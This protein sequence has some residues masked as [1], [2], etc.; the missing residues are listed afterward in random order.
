MKMQ[1]K[2][3]FLCL[4]STKYGH[5]VETDWTERV[6][7]KPIDRV[8][9]PAGPI[10]SGASRPLCS[11]PFSRG[12]GRPS[13]ERGSQDPQS[14]KGG[15]IISLGPVFTQKGGGGVR[16]ICLAFMFMPGFGETGLWLL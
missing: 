4:G 15:Q 14:N 9:N 12:G 11:T 1:K 5:H 8:G 3:S 2:D 6:W 7:S 10:C 13:L 16:G